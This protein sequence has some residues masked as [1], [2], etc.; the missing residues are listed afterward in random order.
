MM[1]Y[2]SYR[3]AT[4]HSLSLT[5]LWGHEASYY[6]SRYSYEDIYITLLLISSKAV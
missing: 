2:Y 5:F 4:L 6:R 1:Y 3:Y